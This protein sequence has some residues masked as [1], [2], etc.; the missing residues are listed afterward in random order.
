M[1]RYLTEIGSDYKHT[2]NELFLL[3]LTIMPVHVQEMHCPSEEARV[4]APQF[5]GCRF[6]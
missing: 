2:R 3:V 1:M 4:S 5:V 6:D